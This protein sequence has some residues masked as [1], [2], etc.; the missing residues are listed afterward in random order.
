LPMPLIRLGNTRT[1]PSDSPVP[2]GHSIPS[3]RAGLIHSASVVNGDLHFF[4]NRPVQPT[5]GWISLAV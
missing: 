5:K 2:Q 3:P 4:A 1:E